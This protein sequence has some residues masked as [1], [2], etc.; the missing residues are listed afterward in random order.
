MW[1]NQDIGS[2]HEATRRHVVEPRQRAVGCRGC[3]AITINLYQGA[4]PTLDKAEVAITQHIAAAV[5]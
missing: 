2:H 5:P 1:L 4:V 3:T